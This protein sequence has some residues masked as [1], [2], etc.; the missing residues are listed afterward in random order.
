MTADDSNEPK[1][2]LSRRLSSQPDGDEP[3]AAQFAAPA[4]HSSAS[5]DAAAAGDGASGGTDLE[6]TQAFEPFAADGPAHT[7]SAASTAPGSSGHGAAGSG[8]TA[9]PAMFSD[10]EWAL[11]EGGSAAGGASAGAAGG[12]AAPGAGTTLPLRVKA[13]E[14]SAPAGSRNDDR[15]GRSALDVIGAIWIA[16]AIPFVIVALAVR[17]VASGTFLK[18]TYFWR[19]GFPEDQY[20][21]TAEDRLHY[22]SYTVDYLYNL[23]SS[24]YLADI[25]TPEGV[26]VFTSGELA[27]MADVKSLVGLLTLIA[28]IGGIGALLFGLYKCRTG[29]TG[30]RGSLRVGSILTVV[31]FAVLG[32]LAVLGWDTFFTR[33]HEVFFAEGTWTFYLDDSLIRLFP[34]QFWIDAGIAVAALT[35]ILSVFAFVLS[36][37][38][39]R[40]AEREGSLR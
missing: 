11:F 25:V 36:F 31:L 40:R 28:I 32:V 24:R 6:D 8:T 2:L 12:T 20:G 39:R 35:L 23:D 33:F 29:G 21:F 22:G 7:A 27:H 1:D 37:V 13:G 15:R 19:P 26:P 5:S 38:G 30:M 18:W 10:E 3:T 4:E 14:P 17:A 34:P 16:A 9:R